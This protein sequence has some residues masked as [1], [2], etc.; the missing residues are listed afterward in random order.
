MIKRLLVISPFIFLIT[1]VQANTNNEELPD[2]DF[3]VFLAEV[4]EATGDGF[5]T[6][7]E[8][9]TAADLAANNDEKQN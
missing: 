3:L 2:A 4:D 9:D 7:L 8:T 6:W 5:D 1:S